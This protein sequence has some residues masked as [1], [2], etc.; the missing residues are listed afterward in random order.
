MG[1]GGTWVSLVWVWVW[2][3][4]FMCVSVCVSVRVCVSVCVCVCSEGGRETWGSLW[5]W[6][7]VG[8]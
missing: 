6:E 1:R 7:V 5:E 8:K 3:V 4:F 2:V